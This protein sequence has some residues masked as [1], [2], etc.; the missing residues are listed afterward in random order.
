MVVNAYELLKDAE[1]KRVY[2]LTGDDNPRTPLN[3]SEQQGNPF[4]G[5]GF[6]F[7]G[8]INIEDLLRQQMG[9]GHP[10]G[11]ERVWSARGRS[12]RNFETE[13][14]ARTWQALAPETWTEL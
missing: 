14:L 1:R 5:G 8:G 4:G 11:N 9:G 2:D 3:N 7:P 12:P 13:T 6:G 10:G